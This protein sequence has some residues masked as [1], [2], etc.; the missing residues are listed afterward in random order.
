[1]YRPRIA[2][3]LDRYRLAGAASGADSEEVGSSESVVADTTAG[4]KRSPATSDSTAMAHGARFFIVP[5]EA[6]SFDAV[7]DPT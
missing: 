2:S 1:M 5:P 6:P 4:A 3:S 7:L